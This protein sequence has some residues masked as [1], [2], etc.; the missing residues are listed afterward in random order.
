M[1]LVLKYVIKSDLCIAASCGC[2][3]ARMYDE[4][5]EACFSWEGDEPRDVGD[6]AVDEETPFSGKSVPVKHMNRVEARPVLMKMRIIC[7]LVI[8]FHYANFFRK[9]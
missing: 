9:M 3:V 2:A 6:V 4:V 7:M 8:C 1:L 5:M